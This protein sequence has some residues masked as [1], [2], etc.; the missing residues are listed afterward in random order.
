MNDEGK[1]VLE[2]D[3]EI[4]YITL[5]RPGKRN[6]MT[7]AMRSS[8]GECVAAADASKAIRVVV[9]RSEGTDFC[10]GADLVDAPEDAMA[11]R[12]RV[13]A[14]QAHHLALVRMQKPVVAAVQ[15]RAVG[16]GASIA[17][18]ADILIMADDA[19]LVFPFVRL[20]VVPDGGA[21][22][23][24]QAKAGPGLALDLLLTAGSLSA[25]DEARAGVTRRVVPAASLHDATAALARD[26]LALPR[27]ALMLTKA[28]CA[29]HWAGTLE[30]V[31]DHE[32]EAFALAT[33]T[34][35]H[36]GAIAALRQSLQRRIH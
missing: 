30:R 20:G 15:G 21:S 14:A 8:F 22:A 2:Q 36:H 25:A 35:G 9:L 28:L 5:R 34:A 18:A 6:A 19:S 16:G 1:V 12:E 11:W 7:S 13:R 26:L 24:L 3:G 31:L 23:L 10:A 17:L 4:G 29:Q 33:T 27:D 32:A